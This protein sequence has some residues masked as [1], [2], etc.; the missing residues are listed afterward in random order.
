MTTSRST[1]LLLLIGLLLGRTASADK[2]TKTNGSV[3]EGSIVSES[4][5]Q[6][7]IRTPFQIELSVRRTDIQSIEREAGRP[8]EEV[9][10]DAALG[11]DRFEAA[12]AL[13]DSAEK[14]AEK[15]EDKERIEKK[16]ADARE[17]IT[18][19]DMARIQDMFSNFDDF[20]QARRFDECE[21]ILANVASTYGNYEA[22]RET[23]QR[24]RALIHLVRAR[25]AEDSVNPVLMER[26]LQQALTLDPDLLDAHL[27]AIRLFVDRPELNERAVG[28]LTKVIEI[29]EG[30]LNPERLVELKYQL[31]EIYY[32][33]GEFEKALDLYS[34][35]KSLAPVRFPRAVDREIDCLSALGDKLLF[36][37]GGIDMAVARYLD[38]IERNPNHPRI[39]TIRRRL[40]ELYLAKVPPEPEKALTQFQALQ[41]EQ[42]VPDLFFLIAKCYIAQ[43]EFDKA[44]ES[45]EKEITLNTS[46][47]IAHIELARLLLERKQFTRAD[48]VLQKARD[49]KPDSIDAYLLIGR[50]RRLQERYPDAKEALTKVLAKEPEHREARL[51]Q[52]LVLL[53]EGK[54]DDAASYFDRVIEDFRQQEMRGGG[55]GT[56]DVRTLTEAT[57]ARGRVDF[58][59][60]QIRLALNRFDKALQMDDRFPETHY[61]IGEARR[62]LSNFEGAREA[63]E[64]AVELDPDEAD[65]HLS[66]AVLFHNNLNNSARAITHYN[67][68][69]DLGGSDYVRVNKWLSEL[70][71]PTR[72]Q[73]AAPNAAANQ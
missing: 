26:E 30:Q 60:K 32:S 24:R 34:E 64:K 14:R 62:Q 18:R 6:V 36:Q 51:L 63:Y 48:D 46:N 37:A 42:S 3:I 65:Y 41:S 10:A 57:V 69:F 20:L 50:L 49:A 13:Y 5:S 53:E 52:G 15:P 47:Y 2:I 40:G 29:G 58:E 4:P 39:R 11:D 25:D 1:A 8:P 27:M 45:L 21:R 7:T 68:Y 54:L 71:A 16:I 61:R 56:S 12:I 59:N 70:G 38:A 28:H 43:G 22:A 55:L 31:A 35:V 73:L 33:R 9:D 67:L 72:D 17:R 23:A 44:I 66:L 19:R